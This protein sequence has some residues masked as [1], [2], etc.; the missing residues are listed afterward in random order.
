MNAQTGKKQKTLIK[1]L[2]TLGLAAALLLFFVYSFMPKPVPVDMAQV[3]LGP[4]Q[5]TVSDEGYTRVHDV[6][7]VSAPITAHLLR[8][9]QHVG[10]EVVAGE[11]LLARLLPTD[12]GFL[13]A[14]S[15]SQ[16]EAT[17]RSAQAALTLAQAERRKAEA[18]VEFARADARRARQ[19]A[20]KD[21]ISK[22]D[23]DRAELALKTANAALDT[24][25]AAEKVRMAELENA[26]AVLIT[27]GK[28]KASDEK[29]V[30][31][32]VSPI[33]GRVLRLL[34]ESENV[35]AAG[36]PLM[37]LGDPA[38]MEIV[39]DLLSRD[40]VKVKAN[41]EV[42]ISGWGG[43]EALNGRVRRVEP[44]GFTKISALGIEEQRVNVIIDLTDPRET[45][46]DLGHGYRVDAA[47]S[48]W[49]GEDI[50][51]V[52]T[53]A[54]F[55]QAG[56]WAVF[57]VVDGEAV[58]TPVRLGRNNGQVA[59]ILEGLSQQDIVV[60]HPSERIEEGVALE[61]RKI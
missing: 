21:S 57:R 56:E 39:V 5:V 33:S 61:A 14:R 36:T 1:R 34:Q 6:Y 55:R 24:A 32:L 25:R 54:L 8:I 45:W 4:M 27:P 50:L 59:Q 53:G 42:K 31:Q 15:K 37:E 46:A 16:A 44:F 22:A 58:M 35:V 12:P 19:M 18:Q 43:D 7:V 60:L 3:S 52:P 47:I 26:R 30:V 49:Q 38:Q 17:V 2:L 13:D 20:E 10:D 23:L 11:T 9:E 41:A 51:Q 28:G 29:G 40:A 48:I